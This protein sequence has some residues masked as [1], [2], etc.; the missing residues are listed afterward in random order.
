MRLLPP[1]AVL[2]AGLLLLFLPGVVNGRRDDEGIAWKAPKGER[3]IFAEAGLAVTQRDEG[4]TLTGRDLD[5]GARRWRHR[6]PRADTPVGQGQ[7]TRVGTTLLASDRGGKIHALDLESGRQRW[8]TPAASGYT[9]PVVATP[10]LVAMSVCDDDCRVEVRSVGDGQ[11]RWHAPTARRSPWLG[12]P[13]IAQA[14]DTDRS[15]WPAS[16]VI[17]DDGS[18]EHPRY[19]VRPLAT[20]KVVA[21]AEGRNQALGVV[22]NVFLRQTEDAT[23]TAI[24]VTTGQ[25]V[26][27]RP[28]H[29]G[30]AVRAPDRSLRWLAIPDGSLLLSGALHDSDDLTIGDELRVLDP[31]TGKLSVQPSHVIGAGGAVVVPADGPPITEANAT[32]GPAAKTPVIEDWIG[33]HVLADGRR[34]KADLSR[35]DTAATTTQVGWREPIPQLAGKDRSGIVVRD[36]RSGRQLVRHARHG[37]NEFY[38]HSEGERL[39]ITDDNRDYVVKR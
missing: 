27:K 20:G 3:V 1:L 11:V 6:F 32:A 25:P 5:S 37:D 13:P 38:V 21:R 16:A 14:F 36:R 15:L 12:S 9:I 22:G 19:E 18:E 29:E 34:Y 31:R 10:E 24:D 7:V 26:W 17:L 4:F 2:V 23:L 39:V 33:H 30:L 28:A 8:E 35:R